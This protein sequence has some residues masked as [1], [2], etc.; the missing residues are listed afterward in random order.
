MSV[1][2][3]VI[4]RDEED[5]ASAMRM[6]PLK[7]ATT[8]LFLLTA[9]TAES[10]WIINGTPICTAT[11]N[12]VVIAGAADQAGGAFFCWGD[13]RNGSLDVYAQRIDVNGSAQWL[14]GGLVVCNAPQSQGDPA[15]VED[16]SG[17]TIIGWTDARNGSLDIYAQRV[18]GGGAMLWV[19]DGV[20]VCTAPGDQ[21]NLSILVDGQGGAIFVWE[22]E[23]VGLE[24][25]IYT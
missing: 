21:S 7:L 14:A 19:D 24:T 12:Q 5:G 8:F 20:P 2:G 6:R 9:S 10:A 13:G 11:G 1:I 3:R 17:G 23:R 4:H 15:I 18:S 16:G 25:D 22:D